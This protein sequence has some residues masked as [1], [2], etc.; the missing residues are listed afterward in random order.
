MF[1]HSRE[2]TAIVMR[3]AQMCF[4]LKLSHRESPGE[5]L[6][7]K[8]MEWSSLSTSRLRSRALRAL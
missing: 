7:R 1:G 4:V 8:N 3:P 6:S 2:K 5:L